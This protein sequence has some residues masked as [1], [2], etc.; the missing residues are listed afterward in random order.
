MPVARQDTYASVSARERWIPRGLANT[1]PIF[2]TRAEGSRDS[3]P[4][5][6]G[7]RD[8]PT[9]GATGPLAE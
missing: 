9:P 7:F 4:S 8:V 6:G 3:E 1:H 2:I 5:D